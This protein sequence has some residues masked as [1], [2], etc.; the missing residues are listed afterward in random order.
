MDKKKV[1]HIPMVVTSLS[2]GTIGAKMMGNGLVKLLTS[3]ALKKHDA[4]KAKAKAWDATGMVV[5]GTMIYSVSAKAFNGV[6]K[7]MMAEEEVDT[8]CLD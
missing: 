6:C 1:K 7:D 2:L 4:E 8:E 5:F 3:V